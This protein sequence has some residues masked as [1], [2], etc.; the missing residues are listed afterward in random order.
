MLAVA[1]QRR[2]HRSCALP[3]AAASGAPSSAG[4]HAPDRGHRDAREHRG[5]DVPA[6]RLRRRH[7]RDA[8][9][10]VEQ[11]AQLARRSRR[12]RQQP[13]EHEAEV[14]GGR[15][16]G[17]VLE[18]DEGTRPP[19]SS[20]LRRLASP[21]RWTGSHV[22][23][24]AREPREQRVGGAARSPAGRAPITSAASAS[25]SGSS[26]SKRRSRQRA[27]VVQRGERRRRARAARG[28]RSSRPSS[29]SPASGSSTSAPSGSECGEHA[30]QP[31]VRI[32][33]CRPRP[34]RPRRW[35]ARARRRPSGP[36]R[37]RCTRPSASRHSAVAAR[38]GA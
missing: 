6:Q 23:R 31:Q 29:R 24:P 13:G 5:G 32:A 17:G 21:C 27:D 12:G 8:R 15:A 20:A 34:R 14:G 37:R 1:E 9:V 26:R 2:A 33:R 19:S 16:G 22:R 10:A 28:A 25:R 36:S 4:P 38:S 35:R 11:R 18:V 7:R 3:P 30:R